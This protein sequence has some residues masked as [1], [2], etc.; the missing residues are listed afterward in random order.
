[1]LTLG[2]SRSFVE[3]DVLPPKLLSGQ[4]INGPSD[5][6]R[7][8]FLMPLYYAPISSVS[9]NEDFVSI[10]KGRAICP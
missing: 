8:V 3:N 10:F 1:M 9:I 5:V 7:T 2:S 4:H 6:L